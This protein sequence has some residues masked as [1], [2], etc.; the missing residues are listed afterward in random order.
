MTAASAMLYAPFAGAAPIALA[1][2]IPAFYRELRL[3]ADGPDRD[4]AEID[5]AIALGGTVIIDTVSDAGAWADHIAHTPHLAVQV[6]G[7][8]FSQD[9]TVND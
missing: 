9:P 2:V 3:L 8:S 4:A 1:I 5:D 6:D 7:N